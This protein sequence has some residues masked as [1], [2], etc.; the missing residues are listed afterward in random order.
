MNLDDSA[1]Q[2]DKFFFEFEGVT[3]VKYYLSSVSA[4]IFRGFVL[5][6]KSK[7]RFG[8][9]AKAGIEKRSEI[10][11][12]LSLIKRVNKIDSFVIDSQLD[13]VELREAIAMI[14]RA[15]KLA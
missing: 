13:S 8:V 11:P 6:E 10:V 1:W 15:S 9:G 14:E 12:F 2:D 4:K 7:F 3:F 5:D